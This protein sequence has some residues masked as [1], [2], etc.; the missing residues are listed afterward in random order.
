MRTIRTISIILAW[1]IL[2][3]IFQAIIFSILLGKF[4]G[5]IRWI[6]NPLWFVLVLSFIILPFGYMIVQDDEYHY[7]RR[8]HGDE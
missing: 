6:F 3:M 5:V 1:G 4:D 7:Q 8:I 2:V